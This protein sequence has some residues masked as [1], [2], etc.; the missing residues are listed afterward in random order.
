MSSQDGVVDA[1]SNPDDPIMFFAWIVLDTDY[2]GEQY[3]Y[4]YCH[5]E[6]IQLCMKEGMFFGET[7][8]RIER[9]M[10]DG[11]TGT[12]KELSRFMD[13]VNRANN[14]TP[15]TLLGNEVGPLISYIEC[16]EYKSSREKAGFGN[17]TFEQLLDRWDLKKYY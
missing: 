16:D 15:F 8:V 4:I 10:R 1:I 6:F 3:S 12:A 14:A 5:N 11:V 2:Y 7:G 9:L 17:F 13:K